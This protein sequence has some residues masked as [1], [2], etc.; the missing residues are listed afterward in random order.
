[1]NPILRFTYRVLQGMA[2]VATETYFRKI[3]FINR[4]YLASDAPLIVIC[5]HPNTVVD[6]LLAV[7]YTREP[8]YLLANYGLFKNP[9]AGAILRTLYCIPVKRVKD[10]AAGEARN[11]DDAFRASEEHLMAGR[12][13]FVAAEGTSYTERHI[14]EFKTGA[15]RILF[16]AEAKTDFKLN[17]RILPIGLTYSDPLKFGSDVVVEVGEPFSADDWRERYEENPVK[18]VDDFT[19]FVEQ[20]FYDLTINCDDVNEDYFLQKLEALLES[21]NRLYTE[22][23]YFRS[24]KILSRIQNWKKTDV[25][26]FA[27]FEQQVETYFS[28]LNGLKIK[29]ANTNTF[30]ST[31]SLTKTLLG[32]PFFII[33]LVPNLIPAWLSDGLVRWLKLD[34]AYDTTVRMLAGFVLFPLLWWLETELF[35]AYWTPKITEIGAF[36]T[37]LLTALFLASGL[38]AW[39]AYTEGSLFFNFQKYKTADSD[40]SLTKLRQPIVDK[41]AEIV[42]ESQL[43]HTSY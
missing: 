35:C 15:A 34:V 2:I 6:P 11:N 25:A 9:I 40:G 41:L 21:E 19:L 33:G 29:D 38:L 10:V 30:Q 32:L 37:I 42:S 14:R 7:M 17:L 16:E 5:N 36:Q 13:L 23:S 18:T 26:G 43:V 8:C 3:V 4:Q 1:M 24:K 31:L 22:G 27:T 20:K 39:R 12:S 28:R